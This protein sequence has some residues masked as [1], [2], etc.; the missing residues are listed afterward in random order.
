MD[1]S[2]SGS[3]VHGI[4]QARILERV[5]I[6]SSKG[7]TQSRDQIRV[8]CISCIGRC[9]LYHWATWEDDCFNAT[10]SLLLNSG[11]ELMMSHFSVYL[12]DREDQATFILQTSGRIW[13]LEEGESN[14]QA[15][16]LEAIYF[17]LWTP[18]LWSRS[19]DHLCVITSHLSFHK[20][21]KIR[22]NWLMIIITSPIFMQLLFS[23]E[24]G[25]PSKVSTFILQPFCKA[26]CQ[27]NSAFAI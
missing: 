7:S 20:A 21:W 23:K 12:V 3:S 9:I 19:T 6:S 2:L 18:E 13:G 22:D 25:G 27:A 4:L 14:T 26:G 15:G 16:P 8:F 11:P 24:T 5:A 10:K 1:C 17:T